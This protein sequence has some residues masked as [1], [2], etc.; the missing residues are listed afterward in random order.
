MP[1]REPPPPIEPQAPQVSPAGDESTRDDGLVGSI[2]P[3]ILI[4]APGPGVDFV[5]QGLPFTAFLSFDREMEA[6]IASRF[7][8]RHSVEIAMAAVEPESGRVVFLTGWDGQ[9]VSRLPAVSHLFPAASIFK[10][11]TAA[12]AMEQ[13]GLTPDSEMLYNGG[14]H[15]LYRSQLKDVANRQTNEISFSES[16]AQSVNPVFGKLGCQL[17]GQALDGW[18]E[19]FGFNQALSCPVEITP[20]VFESPVSPFAEAE[21]ACGFNRTTR[22]TALHAALVAAAVVNNGAM[23]EPVFVDRVEQ[24]PGQ[25]VHRAPLRGRTRT[26]CRKE[27]ADCLRD[28]MVA[29]VESGTARKPFL[30]ASRDRVLRNLVIGGKTGSIN[31]ASDQVHF[32]WFV[33]F[34]QEKNGPRKLAV[35]V[36][37]AHGEFRGTR[38]GEYARLIIRAWFEEEEKKA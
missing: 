21:A 4:H 35:A 20:S 25:V 22:M 15:T 18:A 13:C 34:A 30:R 19:N 5:H 16:F 12:A 24:A 10:I 7:D 38:A 37:A 6:R 1:P 8:T 33:G 26:V 17:G 11:V 14:P 27:T 32:D 23:P 29:T 3:G 9:A 28:L 31:D 36:L 2:D